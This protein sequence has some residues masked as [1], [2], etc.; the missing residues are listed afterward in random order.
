MLLFVYPGKTCDELY[1]FIH[2]HVLYTDVEGPRWLW[3]TV[4]YTMK[5][6]L[7]SRRNGWSKRRPQVGPGLHNCTPVQL[8]KTLHIEKICAITILSYPTNLNEKLHGFMLHCSIQI[9]QPAMT[10]TVGRI[11]PGLPV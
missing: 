9:I 1:L 7:V 4:F 11:Y 6:F 10:G 5:G 8:S 3:F 2:W